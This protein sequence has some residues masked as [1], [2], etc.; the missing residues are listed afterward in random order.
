MYLN[1][2]DRHTIFIRECKKG[3]SFSIR[4]RK[5]NRPF[6]LIPNVLE[7]LPKPMAPSKIDP[8]VVVEVA[9][10]K[11]TP[12]AELLPRE[13]IPEALEETTAFISPLSGVAIVKLH[14]RCLMYV[15]AS[16][17]Y[18]GNSSGQWTEERWS[19]QRFHEEGWKEVDTL[20]IKHRGSDQQHTLF[21]K[22]CDKGD[23][24]RFRTRKYGA[25]YI[26]VRPSK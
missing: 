4:T 16:W 8:S 26:F 18:D 20:T 17:E 15:A 25:P 2:F 6:V 9:A 12:V 21:A 1:L 13:D 22:E 14:R 23:R 19:K 10:S 24:F 7:K 5:Y 3:E 11:S